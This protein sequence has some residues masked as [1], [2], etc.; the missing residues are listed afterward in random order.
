M[1]PNRV[2]VIDDHAALRRTIC[3]LLSKEP[4]LEVI[5]ETASGEDAIEKAEELQPDIVLL[6]ISLP[7][8]S[9]IEAASRIL[10]VSPNSRIIFLSQHSSLHVV[11]EALKVGGHGYVT[12]SDAG[13]E[14]VEAIRVVSDGGCFVSKLI[15]KQGWPQGERRGRS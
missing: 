2:L 4:G 8:I 12:K 9:G 7:G 1:S 5:C 15:R 10:S 11:Q 14:L 3:L 6:D 13:L